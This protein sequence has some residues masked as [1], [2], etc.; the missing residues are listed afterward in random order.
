MLPR[1]TPS[2]HEERK[3]PPPPPMAS[4]PSTQLGI[5]PKPPSG[6]TSQIEPKTISTSAKNKV[7]STSNIQKMANMGLEEELKNEMEENP[8]RIDEKDYNGYTCLMY[9]T[10]HNHL[11]IIND[12]IKRGAD[13][14][15]INKEGL[16]AL[17]LSC[18]NGYDDTI[19]LL[20]DNGAIVNRRSKSFLTPLHNACCSNFV[21]SVELLLRNKCD[22]NALKADGSTA[23]FD[24]CMNTFNKR[25]SLDNSNDDSVHMHMLS[26][27]ERIAALLIDSGIDVNLRRKPDNT[28]ILH[29]ASKKGLIKI[30]NMLLKAGAS[31][32][33]Q[34]RQGNT[35]LHLACCEHFSEIIPLLMDAGADVNICNVKGDTPLHL[36]CNYSSISSTSFDLKGQLD[37]DRNNAYVLLR[38][39][40]DIDKKNNDNLPPMIGNLFVTKIDIVHMLLDYHNSRDEHVHDDWSYMHIVADIGCYE[41]ALE[42]YNSDT[43]R[44]DDVFAKNKYGVTPF[45][46]VCFKGHTNMLR[47]FEAAIIERHLL[48]I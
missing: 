10:F 6:L 30:V 38:N 4:I 3:H 29:L 11:G 28:S 33:V 45:H 41:L 2:A 19:Q 37:R 13:V 35:A 8:E 42:W 36:C 1:A 12:L 44:L 25:S 40:A 47:L 39:G 43:K 16:S 18:L 20:I 21:S 24:V 5:P 48:C 34:D 15:A 23:L 32:N 31:C 7:I 22:V 46:I 14:N 26:P 17:H 27:Q 9:A